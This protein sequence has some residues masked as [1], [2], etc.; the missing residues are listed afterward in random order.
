MVKKICLCF[1]F[2]SLFSCASKKDIV[3]FQG[4]SGKENEV[5]NYE[6]KLKPDDLLQIF[7]SAPD[8]EAANPFNLPVAGF[9]IGSNMETAGQMRYQLYL[10]DN[11]GNIN[12]PVLGLIKVGGLTKREALNKLNQELYKYIKDPVV[13]IRIV[14]YKVSVLGE[15][16]H[17]GS[18]DIPTERISLPEAL[19]MAGDMT[20]YGNRKN[21]L[22]IRDIDGKKS[23]NYVDMTNS[24]LVNSP[25]FYLSQND[26]VYVEPNNTRVKSASVGP[27]VTATISS[28][29]L[30][31]TIVAL[32][33]RYN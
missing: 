3:Y 11:G 10:V 19:S 12:F 18:F 31:V 15:V 17:P 6:P 23:Y 14:N 9:T 30:L 25:F 2:L 4:N 32:V 33:I 29:S 24:D 16:T 21:V 8:P 5:V 28:I 1:V 22:I 26:V 20:I 27:N 7:V 13:N